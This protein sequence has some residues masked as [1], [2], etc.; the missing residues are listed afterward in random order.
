MNLSITGTRGIPNNYGGFEQFAEQL[1][2][3]LAEK[4][5][6]VTVYN[7]RFHPYKEFTFNKVNIIHKSSPEYIAGGAANYL[8]DYRCIR[9]AI[10]RKSDIILQCGYASAAPAYRLLNFRDSKVVTHVDGMEWKRLKWGKMI[11]HM[12][13]NSEKIAIKNSNHLVCDHPIIQS[14]YEQHYNIRPA[15]IPYGADLFD[16]SEEQVINEFNL[17][18]F[19]YYLIIARL[20]PENHIHTIIKGFII[21]GKEEKLIIVGNTNTGY[22]KRLIKIYSSNDKILFCND[23]FDK[24]ILNNLRYFS[25]T[26]FHGHSV[27]G[28]NPS[29]LEAMAANALVIAHDNVYNKHILNENALFFQNEQDLKVVLSAENEWIGKRKEMVERNRK[30]ILEEYQWDSVVERYERLFE[31]IKFHKEPQS[32]HKGSQSEDFNS[33]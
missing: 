13:K 19:K 2:V 25:K 4:G 24:K 5:H 23:I 14:Y 6:M 3:R 32:R 15:C 22:G 1:A 10:K 33:L 7:P 12:I 21:S 17:E 30:R 18:P 16:N 9:D 28:T 20:E 26:Y 29:L 27:G 11:H 31:K 8:Y